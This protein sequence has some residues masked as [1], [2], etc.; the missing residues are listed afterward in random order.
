MAQR[1]ARRPGPSASV[2]AHALGDYSLTGSLGARNSTWGERNASARP[3]YTRRAKGQDGR[4]GM[5]T[6][7]SAAACAGARGRGPNQQTRGS[8]S[9][10]SLP[11]RSV[12]KPEKEGGGGFYLEPG[13]HVAP[14]PRGE[15]DCV[16]LLLLAVREPDPAPSYLLHCSHYLA[17]LLRIKT[18]SAST[19]WSHTDYLF[20]RS[21]DGVKVRR[22]GNSG[23]AMPDQASPHELRHCGRDVCNSTASPCMCSF[24]E[25][26]RQGTNLNFAGFDV[27]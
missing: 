13:R 3:A 26:K 4:T 6:T 22:D 18:G 7:S 1:R 20:L 2:G 16:E 8:F 11:P 10:S 23:A 17:T 21:S 14:V 15:Y 5:T 9:I 12:A 19:T 24:R 27:V 25:T